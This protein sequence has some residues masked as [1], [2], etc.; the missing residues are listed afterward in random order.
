MRY[1]TLNDVYDLMDRMN[2]RS[3]YQSLLD[4]SVLKAAN[5]IMDESRKTVRLYFSMPNS[6]KKARLL[7]YIR[8]S[9]KYSDNCAL[10]MINEIT[11]DRILKK[12]GDNGFIVISACKSNDKKGK[13]VPDEVN[14]ARTE[15]LR[16]VIKNS[17]YSFREAYGGYHDPDYAENADYEYSFIVFNYKSVN[18]KDGEYIIPPFNELLELSKKWC[19]DFD[20]YSVMVKAP[21]KPAIHMDRFGNKVNKRE[22]DK[23]WKNDFTQPFYTSLK[24]RNEVRDEIMQKLKTQYKKYRKNTLGKSLS[25]DEWIEKI[26]SFMD[27]YNKYKFNMADTGKKPLPFFK[28]YDKQE[29]KLDFSLPK[30]IGKRWTND[31]EY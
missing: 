31:I 6:P 26:K 13:K 10:Q 12:H 23:V 3:P 5:G 19:T 24:S 27:K 11:L 2:M 16:E 17:K 22:S 14:K 7:R 30:T 1:D 4:E 21:G 8:E 15:E 28:W 25:F 18:S 29:G 9:V 20:Q